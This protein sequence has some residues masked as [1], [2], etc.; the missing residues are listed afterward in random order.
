MSNQDGS[1]ALALM[2]WTH[3]SETSSHEHDGNAGMDDVRHGA[4]LRSPSHPSGARDCSL[5]Q[6]LARIAAQTVTLTVS[7]PCLP[8]LT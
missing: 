4:R 3:K 6:V 1:R 5:D 8:K 2:H 7:Q